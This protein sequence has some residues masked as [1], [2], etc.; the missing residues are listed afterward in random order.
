MFKNIEVDSDFRLDNQMGT[1]KIAFM[2]RCI[3]VF[4]SVYW[5]YSAAVL[6]YHC[7]IF[8]GTVQQKIVPG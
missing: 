3:E 2:S 7:V 5:E 8:E 1:L 4:D 6:I